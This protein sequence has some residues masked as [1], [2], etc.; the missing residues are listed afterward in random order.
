MA[1]DHFVVGA[2]ALDR[3]RPVG[4]F[5]EG[6]LGIRE[7]RAGDHPA[8]AVEMNRL[9]VGM[10]DEGAFAAADQT[11]IEGSIGHTLVLLYL[12]ECSLFVA[13]IPN[14]NPLGAGA[15]AGLPAPA[16]IQS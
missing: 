16:S 11:D 8:G 1:V 5:L 15:L 9:L 3:V 6:D 4:G 10:N 7:Q 2:V 12:F 14:C 13:A